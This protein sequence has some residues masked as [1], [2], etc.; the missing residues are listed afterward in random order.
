M[1]YTVDSLLSPSPESPTDLLVESSPSP[2]PSP[3]HSILAFAPSVDAS[4]SSPDI[5]SSSLPYSQTLSPATPPTSSLSPMLADRRLVSHAS[6]CS[7][8]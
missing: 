3:S 7:K 6:L 4:A 5:S 8:D 1:E 2:S